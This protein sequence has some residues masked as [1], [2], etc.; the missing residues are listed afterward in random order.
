[1]ASQT[2]RKQ[3]HKYNT[4]IQVTESRSSPRKHRDPGADT[5]TPTRTHSLAPRHGQTF[6]CLPGHTDRPTVCVRTQTHAHLCEDTDTQGPQAGAPCSSVRA[7]LPPAAT[8]H[9]SLC[10]KRPGGARNSVSVSRAPSPGS[11][12]PLRPHSSLA[13]AE[14]PRGVPGKGHAGPRRHMSGP[15]SPGAAALS[16]SCPRSQRGG[17]EECAR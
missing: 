15:L 4:S 6:S 12:A 13:S 9:L 17:P 2:W 16:P 1:M 14:R 8:C 5:P 10:G 3:T 11:A 7:V